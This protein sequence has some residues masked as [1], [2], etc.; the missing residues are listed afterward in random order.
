MTAVKIPMR[1]SRLIVTINT[2]TCRLLLHIKLDL[3]LECVRPNPLTIV[4]CVELA[5]DC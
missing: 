1:K 5:V 3:P 2:V 4:K